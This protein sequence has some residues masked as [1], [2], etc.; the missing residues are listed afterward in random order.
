MKIKCKFCGDKFD[1]F[2]P[3]GRPSNKSVCPECEYKRRNKACRDRYIPVG[4]R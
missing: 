3:T 2:T 4:A 1:H